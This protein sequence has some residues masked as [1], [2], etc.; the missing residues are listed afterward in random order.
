V[1]SRVVAGLVVCWMASL[2]ACTEPAE[3]TPLRVHIDADKAVRELVYDVQVLVETQFSNGGG[4]STVFTKRFVPGSMDEWPIEVPVDAGSTKPNYLVTATARDDRGAVVAEVRALRDSG[5]LDRRGIFLRFEAACVRIELCPQGQTCHAGSC[6]DARYEASRDASDDSSEPSDVQDSGPD[7]GGPTVATEGDTCAPNG[8]RACLEEGSRTPF[9]CSGGSW[10]PASMC[11][12]DELCSTEP[13]AL[14]GTCRKIANECRGQLPDV[15]F[16]DSEMMV[17][18]MNSFKSEIRHCGSNEHCVDASEARCECITGFVPGAAGCERPSNCS[19]EHGGCDLLASCTMRG[20][21]RQCGD[22]PPGYVGEGDTGCEPLLAN[23]TP[24]A[25]ELVPAFDPTVHNYRVKATLLTQRLT[26]TPNAP[27]AERLEVN[28]TA[29]APGDN[30]TTPTLPLAEYPVKLTLTSRSGA[31]SDY[32]VIVERMGKQTA[33]IKASNPGDG[34]NFGVG[35]AIW[36]DTLVVGAFEE[37]SAATKIDGDQ[38][39]N[40]AA[41]TGAAYVF[42]QRGDQWEQ[43]A[44]LKAGDSAASDHFGARVAIEGDTIVVGTLVGALDWNSSRTADRPG[45]A[46][47]FT[48]SAGQWSQTARLEAP[49]KVAG[50]RFGT[51]VAISRDTIAIGAPSDGGDGSVIVFTRAETGWKSWPKIKA[52]PALA[53]A[54]FGYNLSLSNDTL[55]VAAPMDNRPVDGGGSAYVYVRNGTDWQFQQRLLP[56]PTSSGATFGYGVAVRGDRVLVGAPRIESIINPVATTEPGEVFAYERADGTWTQTQYLRG[57]LP[58]VND[59]FGSFVALSDTAALIGA[60]NDASGARGIGAD[61]SRRDAGYAGAA[62]LYALESDGW[63]VS[64][65]LKPSNTDALDAFGLAGALSADTAVVGANWES[66]KSSGING[67]ADDDSS[68]Q[69]GAVYVFR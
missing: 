2:F 51:G 44:Y 45:A 52:V 57:T 12:E 16:C 33:Y 5:D 66:S 50:D 27:S 18:C 32:T 36:G 40:S 68:S 46:Y 3:R 49:D 64:V 14:R 38:S 4:W 47:V 20:S 23:L 10:R 58:R 67:N 54:L 17:V 41:G 65:Y 19:V 6:V 8:A 31:A 11:G 35:T 48:R 1:E 39:D 63:K 28:G 9:E 7:P 25:G 69:A 21:E 24:S 30:W 56:N 59:G 34:D 61:A 60:C 15:P 22:C 37:D 55:L 43:Q 29:V 13:G 53:G 42:V 62:Y 26:L